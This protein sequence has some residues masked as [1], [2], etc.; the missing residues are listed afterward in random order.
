[1]IISGCSETVVE[2]I[3]TGNNN[4]KV[5]NTDKIKSGEALLR[6]FKLSY[7]N[8]KVVYSVSQD[9][10][11]DSYEDTFVVTGSTNPK[12]WYIHPLGDTEVILEAWGDFSTADLFNRGERKHLIITCTSKPSITQIWVFSLESGKPKQIFT[13]ISNQ[14]IIIS[15]DGFNLY[16]KKYDENGK[17]GLAICKYIWDDSENKYIKSIQEA[18]EEN[19]EDE[20]EEKPVDK[21]DKEDKLK[22]ID[23]STF[24]IY[25]D[26]ETGRYGYVDSNREVV[27]KAEF[28]FVQPFSESVAVV[29]INSKYGCIDKY[30]KWIVEPEYDD[31]KNFSEGLAAVLRNREW[32]YINKLGEVTIDFAFN[33]ANSFSEGMAAV[34]VI[35]QW[36]Y[37]DNKGEIVIKPQFDSDNP[38]NNGKVKVKYGGKNGTMDK[39][40]KILWGKTETF[41]EIQMLPVN[42]ENSDS[43]F[44]EFYDKLLL[45]V[46]EKDI[47]FIKAHADDKIS[48]KS[49]YEPGI[50]GFISYW[51]LNTEPNESLFWEIINNTLTLGGVFT[52][53]EKTEFVAP[54]IA[55]KYPESFDPYVYY[56]TMDEDVEMYLEPNMN[57]PIIEKL[58]YLIVKVLDPIVKIV[59]DNGRVYNW[60]KI[61]LPTGTRG[62]IDPWYIRGA[63]GYRVIFSKNENGIWKIDAFISG[64][65]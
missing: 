10:N 12:L 14:S 64:K 30:G 47:E 60:S 44:M 39:E 13:S 51:N 3:E 21:A 46:Q 50:E 7:P 36:G 17:E 27:I 52:D 9:I 20:N 5:E 32:G 35:S 59:D 8:E 57:S 38:F 19:P 63:A 58:D 37:I 45:A 43:D 29:R 11:N 23:P 16:L 41:E 15:R 22:N 6:R 65:L 61:Q 56:V 40:G 24:N 49:Q 2:P 31:M 25:R 34:K 53:E 55:A 54:Y 1:M 28:D 18:T 33:V 26:D 62:Y 42:D 4:P 48:Y